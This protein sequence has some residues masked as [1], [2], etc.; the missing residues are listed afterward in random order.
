[1][2][3]LREW[4][5]QILVS[6]DQLVKVLVIDFAYVLHLTDDKPSADE[7]ISSYVGRGELRGDRW[8]LILAPMIDRLFILLGEA[9]GHCQR[10]VE[11]AFVG[12]A[13][14]P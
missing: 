7:T 4:L 2:K 8:A 6:I 3:R 12:D 5:Q 14:T 13:P 9:P 10:N 11:T 1:M